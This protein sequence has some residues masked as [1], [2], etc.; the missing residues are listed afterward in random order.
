MNK[1]WDK[2][3]MK[4][5]KDH[6]NLYLWCDALL[7]TDI[8]EKSRNNSWNNYELCRSHYLNAPSLSWDAMLDMAKVELEL[9]PD[10]DM[11]VFLEKVVPPPLSAVGGNRFSKECCLRKW[12][13]S[14]CL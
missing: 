4:T 5:M 14:F 8:S 11:Y 10:P 12:V 13:I 1:V 2:S 6:Q 9:I 3:E 7:L